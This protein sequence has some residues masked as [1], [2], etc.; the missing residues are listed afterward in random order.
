MK[1]KNMIK[2]TKVIVKDNATFCLGNFKGRK[3]VIRARG[4]ADTLCYVSIEG[5]ARRIPAKAN[6]LKRLK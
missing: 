5:V 6:E 2:G 1:P 3:A 4:I